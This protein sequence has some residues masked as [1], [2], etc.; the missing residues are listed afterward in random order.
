MENE[1]IKGEKI[2][3]SLAILMVAAIVGYNAFFVGEA[4]EVSD[5][6]SISAE[7]SAENK[8]NVNDDENLSININTASKEELTKLNGIGDAKAKNIIDYRESHGGF[9]KIEEIVNVK[10]I[11]KNIFEKIK[12]YIFV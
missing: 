9:S 11:S 10:G 5:S 2:F 4:K 12:N 3:I 6:Y 7:D 8:D 1:N